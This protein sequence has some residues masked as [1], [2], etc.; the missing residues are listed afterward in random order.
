MRV[1]AAREHGDFVARG[2]EMAREERADLPGAAGDEDL[3]VV[4][5]AVGAPTPS[6]FNRTLYGSGLEC[7]TCEG[8]RVCMLVIGNELRA[9][10]RF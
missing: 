10:L 2:V 1:G 6:A 5:R 9:E 4:L 7:A 3:H 8:Y